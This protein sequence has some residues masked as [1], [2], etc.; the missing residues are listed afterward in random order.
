MPQIE[1]RPAK[2]EDREAVLA[3][4]VSTW[5]WGDYMEYVWDDWLHNPNGLLLVATLDEKPIGVAHIRMLSETDAWLE[6]MRVDPVHRQHG[7]ANALYKGQI[8]E[9]LRRGAT[10]AR[11]VTESTNTAALR[12][13][14]RGSMHRVGAF[15]P[16]TAA[17]VTTLPKR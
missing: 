10:N 2:P 8:A 12:L 4:C 7:V 5:E 6:G 3:F 15:A 17:P 14:E 11:L 13:I 9:A 16:Y 1:I